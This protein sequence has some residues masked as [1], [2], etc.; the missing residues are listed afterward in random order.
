MK[1][2][3]PKMLVVAVGIVFGIMLFA[4]CEEEEKN[5]S[6]TTSDT[7]RSRLIA[8]EN[9]QLKKQIEELK[10]THAKEIKRQKELLGKCEREKKNLEK[11]SSK[12]VDSYMN[13]LLRPL[14]EENAKLRE[15]IETLKAQIEKLKTE[16]EEP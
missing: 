2:S 9:V 4:G 6:N 12:G 7:K 13:D 16:H 5:S 11:L 8:I 3:A 1:E 10:K 14:A 15:E